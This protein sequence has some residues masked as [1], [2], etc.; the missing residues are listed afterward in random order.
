MRCFDWILF[1][2][3]KLSAVKTEIISLNL[4]FIIYLLQTQRSSELP[5][6]LLSTKYCMK[7]PI[8]FSVVKLRAFCVI[9]SPFRKIYEEYF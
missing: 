2:L 4:G 8:H 7:M 9:I 3:S 6:E 5:S 1:T